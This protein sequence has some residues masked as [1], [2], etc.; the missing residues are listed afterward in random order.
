MK[1]QAIQPNPIEIENLK[2]DPST[3]KQISKNEFDDDEVSEEE[4]DFNKADK[5]DNYEEPQGP[6]K[7]E[8]RNT[9]IILDDDDD[10][11]DEF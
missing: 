7:D 3:K 2:K 1:N 10:F 11:D 6:Q 8:I 4:D 9:E 5:E